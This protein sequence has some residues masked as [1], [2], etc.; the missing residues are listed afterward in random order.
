MFDDMFTFIDP[1]YMRPFFHS[2]LGW[3]MLTAVFIL[4][5]AGLWL[6][7]RMVKVQV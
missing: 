3:I 1:N 2:M 7:F 4:D 5:G 6:M